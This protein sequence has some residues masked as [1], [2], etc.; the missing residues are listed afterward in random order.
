MAKKHIYVIDEEK[1]VV[2]VYL[3]KLKTALKRD[4]D[5]IQYLKD[6]C[7]YK[8]APF[9]EEEAK[10][11]DE[12][13]RKAKEKAPKRLNQKYIEECLGVDSDEY[14]TYIAECEKTTEEGN[15]VGFLGGKEWFI[16]NYPVDIKDIEKEISKD[17]NKKAILDKAIEINE[18]KKENKKK[19]MAEVVRRVYWTKIFTRES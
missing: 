13:S 16:K 6:F 15:K 4:L 7:G 14:K 19:D 11:Y 1:E 10:A 3:G 9:T 12:E 8:V 5:Y 17:K 18:K 2:R